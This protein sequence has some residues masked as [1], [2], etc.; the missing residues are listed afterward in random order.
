MLNFKEIWFFMGINKGAVTKGK[1]D[2][3]I[4]IKLV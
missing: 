3:I 4:S 2:A 1:Y